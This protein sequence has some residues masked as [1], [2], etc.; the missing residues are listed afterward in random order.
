M[1]SV[2]GTPRRAATVALIGL[3][4]TQLAQ[5]L[6]DSHGRLVVVTTV[7]SFAVLAA[8]INT[9]GLSNLFGCTP[10]GPVGWGQAFLATAVAA[11]V[12]ALARNCSCAC[13][14]RCG[15]TPTPRVTT[16]QSSTTARRRTA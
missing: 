16:D 10:V 5:T 11:V 3:V 9:P 1:A 8:V 2:T 7:G 6:A 13:R 14:R 4:S 12:S 15:N